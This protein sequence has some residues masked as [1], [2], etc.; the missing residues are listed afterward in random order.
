MIHI[1]RVSD[2]DRGKEEGF[3]IT[4]A[5]HVLMN[6]G[7][8]E[9]AA[10]AIAASLCSQMSP[11]HLHYHTFTHPNEI[12]QFVAQKK[13]QLT[14]AEKLAIL[15]HDAVYIP[16]QTPASEMASA[17][18]MYAQIGWFPD[19]MAKSH[20][21]V[22]DAYKIIEDTSRH[23]S[24]AEHEISHLMMDLDIHTMAAAEPIFRKNN[25]LLQLEI[26]L[27]NTDKRKAFLKL[28]LAKPK[29]FYKLTDL[30]APARKNLEAEIARLGG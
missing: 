12:F 10:I 21:V 30:E 4:I 2:A 9:S 23:L 27:N 16:G 14:D 19:V 17:E 8:P 5:C 11:T 7:V 25:D 3:F 6:I 29:I 1:H 20:A 18:F 24:G 28:F 22:E 13:L 15:Y 26:G